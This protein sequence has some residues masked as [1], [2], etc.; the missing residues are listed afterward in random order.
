M[1]YTWKDL[2]NQ[3]ASEY[4]LLEENFSWYNTEEEKTIKKNVKKILKLIADLENLKVTISD[5]DRAIQLFPGLPSAYEPLVH[6]IQYE[7]GKET[8]NEFLT[9]D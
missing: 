6:T 8:V 3:V 7:T 1:E 9:S 4:N 2:P 5:E